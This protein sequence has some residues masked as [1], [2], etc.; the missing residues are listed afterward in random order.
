MLPAALYLT[1]SRKPQS[2]HKPAANTI[3]GLTRGLSLSNGQP[4]LE[5]L[6]KADSKQQLSSFSLVSGALLT[7]DKRV[8]FYAITYCV[9]EI[10]HFYS[11]TIIK[12]FAAL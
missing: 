6:E 1:H 3:F 10:Y 12:P 9:K 8:S 5:S 11:Y 7:A 4:L 2:N